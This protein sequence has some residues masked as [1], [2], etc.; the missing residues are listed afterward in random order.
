MCL[1]TNVH[2]YPLRLV[3]PSESLS[4]NTL[5]FLYFSNNIFEMLFF[6]KLKYEGETYIVSWSICVH[7]TMYIRC[8]CILYMYM[9]NIDISIKY[10]GCDQK[11]VVL[12]CRVCE[13]HFLNNKLVYL[14]K[15]RSIRSGFVHVNILVAYRKLCPSKRWIY[16]E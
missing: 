16:L 5:Q 10:S 9:S 2:Q 4:E 11:P 14:S 15:W 6:I 1:C 13:H 8:R 7:T 3:I 12:T